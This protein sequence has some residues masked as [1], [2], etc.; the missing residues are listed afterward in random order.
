[1]KETIHIGGY[2]SIKVGPIINDM[3][4]LLKMNDRGEVKINILHTIFF[5]NGNT[6]ID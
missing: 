1:V 6:I 2:L 4:Q 3:F 5:N